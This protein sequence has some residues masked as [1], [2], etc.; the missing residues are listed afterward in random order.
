MGYI[1]LNNHVKGRI[2][3]IFCDIWPWVQ[4]YVDNIICKTKSLL[5]LLYKLCILFKVFFHY[6]ILI[7]ST[8]LYLNYLNIGFLDQQVKF[9]SLNI[10]E[11]KL[12][13]IWLLINFD[14]LGALKYYF[15]LTG[16]LQNYIYSWTQLIALFQTLKTSLLR[17]A[18]FGGLQCSAYVS[19]TKLSFSAPPNLLHFWAFKRLWVSS[20][21]WFPMTLKK[22]YG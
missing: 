3:N 17:H 12:K 13:V 19:K 18:F 10:L 14:I 8:K 22:S 15:S 16:Y 4:V 20:L 9:L 11:K 7:K 5:D 21:F 6:N 2:N 1:N